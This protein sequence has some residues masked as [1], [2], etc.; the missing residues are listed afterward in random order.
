MLLVLTTGCS[1]VIQSDSNSATTVP[2]PSSSV[3]RPETTSAS[4]QPKS[5][6]SQ[7]VTHP[8]PPRLGLSLL[9]E[10]AQ[11]YQ[12]VYT[13]ILSAK[14]S[15]DMTMYELEDQTAEADLASDARRGVDVRV[16]LDKDY[17]A[18]NEN[19]DAYNFL[20]SHDVH[21]VWAYPSEIF[22]QKTI[23]VDGSESL[24]MT[25]NLTS[26]YYSATRDFA[27][28]DALP[29]DIS[30]IEA[31]F[32]SD[33]SGGRPEPA[34]PGVDLVWSPG[35]EPVVVGMINSATHSLS[36]ENEEMDSGAIV[37]ALEAAASRGVQVDLTMTTNSSWASAFDQLRAAGVRVRLY[38]DTETALYIHAKVILADAGTSAQRVFIGSENF[39]TA[40]L[41]Y[42]RELGLITTDPTIVAPVGVTLSSDFA[43]GSS[44]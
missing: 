20:A 4:T 43:G 13:F 22:H 23:T 34:S 9:T 36:I 15:V 44:N 19:E 14:K 28:L 7:P 2:S 42:N 29:A 27:V 32:D 40:S 30:A 41:D 6:K 11:T 18:G 3:F 37:E 35:A 10:P 33:Y 31:A 39:S 26:E 25:G 1:A 21:V 16:V 5:A 17:T 8:A 24:I 38:S 12:P